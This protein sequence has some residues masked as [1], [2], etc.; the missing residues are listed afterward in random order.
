MAKLYED[1]SPP[2]KN[3]DSPLADRIRPQDLE[4]LF[5]Q[6][7]LIG[8]G[9]PLRKQI[10]IKR[11][12]SLILWGP[13]GSGKTSLAQILARETGSRFIPLSAVLS[14]IRDVRRIMEEAA[15]DRR[16][17]KRQTLLFIDEIHRFN[18]AQQDAFLSYVERGEIL[19]VGATTEN[20]SFEVIPAL[21]SRCQVHR[22]RSLAPKAIRSILER[23]LR[24][25]RKLSDLRARVSSDNLD[26]IGAASGGDARRALNLLE[27]VVQVTPPGENGQRQVRRQ[28]LE[29]ALRDAP[30]RYDKAGE[31]HFNMISAFQKSIRNS[32]PDA[33][34]YWLARMLEAGEDPLYVARRIIRTASEDI[35]NADPRA[36]QLAVA[37]KDAVHFVGLPEGK[38][39]LAQAVTYMAVAPKSNALEVAYGAV[40]ED[41]RSGQADP[42]PRHL[43]NPTTREMRRQGYGRGYEYAHED[44]EGITGMEC[45]PDRLV[46][47]EYY[48]PKDAGF[49]KT[50]RER[51]RYWREKVAARRKKKLD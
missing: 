46:G 20:P 16:S 8:E 42:V 14:S 39:A 15:A 43:R 37:A 38:L 50:I 30:R 48:R 11:L 2:G 36:L 32:D 12:Y 22:M 5:G 18:K 26:L 33:A 1:A 19:L 45:L 10:E 40:L 29:A 49:E 23:A 44:P 41:L 21:L 13:P 31:D 4:D 25:D 35:G 24:V 47:R 27:G 17:N 6:D 9:T 3:P 34:L 7:E 28:D 51:I